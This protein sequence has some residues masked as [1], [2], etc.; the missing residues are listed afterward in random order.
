MILLDTSVLSRVFRRQR[1]GPDERRLHDAFQAMMDSDGPLGLPAIVLQEV[2]SGI[3]TQRQFSELSAKLLTAFT[4]LPATVRDHLAAAT[5]KSTCA[6]SGLNVSGIDCLIAAMAMEGKHELFS[7]DR[8]F[9]KIAKFVP[10]KLFVWG[11][12]G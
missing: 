10:L 4:V 9:V 7:T 2:L 1:P 3:R 5:V 6:R 11:E 8:D 12:Q